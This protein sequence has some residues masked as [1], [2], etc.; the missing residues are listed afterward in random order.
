M[1]LPTF[2]AIVSK[3]A[4]ESPV[5]SISDEIRTLLF[6]YAERMDAGDFEGVGAL[7]SEAAY[8]SENGAAFRGARELCDVLSA[9][10]ILYAGSPRTKHVTTNV[11]VETGATAKEATA[12]SYFSVLQSLEDFPLQTVVAGRY[13]DRFERKNG[14]W[15][16]ADRLVTMELFGDLS[17]HLRFAPASGG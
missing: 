10:V 8:R 11:I 7:F 3:P 14:V 15:R 9:V 5:S 17:H 1:K 16:F 6:T 13:A 2:A 12:R 4:G